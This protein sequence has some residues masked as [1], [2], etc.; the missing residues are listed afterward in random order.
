MHMLARALTRDIIMVLFSEIQR[1]YHSC[2][3]VADSCLRDQELAQRRIPI[4]LQILPF[5][6]VGSHQ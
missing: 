4:F 2:K 5:V 3:C 1:N 6:M